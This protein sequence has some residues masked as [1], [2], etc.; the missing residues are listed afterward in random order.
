MGRPSGL[1]RSFSAPA[2]RKPTAAAC[3]AAI[4]QKSRL[5]IADI[6]CLHYTMHAKQFEM[7]FSGFSADLLRE[8]CVSSFFQKLKA[9]RTRRKAAEIAA[10]NKSRGVITPIPSAVPAGCL[11]A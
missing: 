11:S 9:Q 3:V 10:N 6:E 4:L 7:V 2:E 8:L 5:E 1:A